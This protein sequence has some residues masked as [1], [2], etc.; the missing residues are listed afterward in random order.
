MFW[1][2]PFLDRASV[3][4]QHRRVAELDDPVLVPAIHADPI[5]VPYQAEEPRLSD[6]ALADALLGL[7]AATRRA[8]LAGFT[9]QLATG[10]S[11]GVTKITGRGD[12]VPL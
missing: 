6:E 5:V 3:E 1:P 7:L 4:E 9:V 11:S 10:R 2:Y 12:L 8:R